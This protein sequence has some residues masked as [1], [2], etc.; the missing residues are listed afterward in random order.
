MDAQHKRPVRASQRSTNIV[1]AAIS[2]IVQREAQNATQIVTR[3]NAKKHKPHQCSEDGDGEEGQEEEMDVELDENHQ[4]DQ[5]DD[6]QT[7]QQDHELN[8]SWNEMRLERCLSCV[9]LG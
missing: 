4:R 2:L 5:H 9:L 7:E 3:Q 1:S 6:Q 8:Q